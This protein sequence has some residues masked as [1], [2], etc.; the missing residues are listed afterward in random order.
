[1]AYCNEHIYIQADDYAE[2]FRRS[3]EPEPQQVQDLREVLKLYDI[4]KIV[5]SGEDDYLRVGLACPASACTV[6]QPIA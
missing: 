4:Q 6:G 3:G 1:M 2:T 5:F